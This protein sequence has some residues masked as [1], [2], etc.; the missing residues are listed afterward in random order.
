MALLL[1]ASAA[2]RAGP[3]PA[4]QQAPPPPR[5]AGGERVE[6][7]VRRPAFL[8]GGT[9]QA[10]SAAGTI[11]DQGSS[12]D[13]Q[14][15]SEAPDAPM[16]RVLEGERGTITLRLEGGHKASPFPIFTYGRWAI[17]GGTGAYAGLRGE[18]TYTVTDDGSDVASPEREL[19]TL[20]GVI[21]RGP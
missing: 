3:A 16:G 6:I 21:R 11:H 12:R 18:G 17:V 15:G 19:H 14:V 1:A 5:R 20:V 9:F 4:S 13:H 2:A 10:R 8:F 7:L